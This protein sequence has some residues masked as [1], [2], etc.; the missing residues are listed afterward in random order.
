MSPFSETAVILS[1]DLAA[2]EGAS[3]MV[4]RFQWSVVTVVE[5]ANYAFQFLTSV[6]SSQPGPAA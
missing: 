3:D 4:T 6:N 5:A 1:R 2:S